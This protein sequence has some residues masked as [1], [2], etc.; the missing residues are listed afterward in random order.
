MIKISVLYPAKN[1]ESFDMEYYRTK[2]MPM[3]QRL[4]GSACKGIAAE[5]GVAGG[6]P[7]SPAPFTAIGELLFNSVEEFQTAFTPHAAEIMGDI[8]NYTKIEP[9]IQISEITL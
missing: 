6:T 3:V 9:L 1:G 4:C 2:H 7:G 5:G 8:K